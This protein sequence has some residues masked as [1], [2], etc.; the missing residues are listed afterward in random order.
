MALAISRDASCCQRC[1]TGLSKARCQRA[2]RIIGIAR[3]PLSCDEY[4]ERLRAELESA[5]GNDAQVKAALPDFLQLIGYPARLMR[6]AKTDGRTWS[7]CL[8]LRPHHVRVFY[9]A[10][11]P[12]LFTGICERLSA[13]GLAAGNARVVIEKPVGRSLQSAMQ[14]NDA[15][16]RAFDERQTFRIDHYLGKE[17]VQN[18]IALRFGNALF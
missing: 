17:T 7:T 9:L 2:S 15:V 11:S 18:L 3:D 8:G 1:C 14:I 13:N 10:T 12:S 4:R 6:L 5:I 16:G